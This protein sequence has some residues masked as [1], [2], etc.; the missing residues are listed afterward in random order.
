[1]NYEHTLL[2]LARQN[3]RLIILT[4]ENR[5]PIRSFAEE[6]PDRFVDAGIAEQ[7]LAG[8]AAGLALRGRIPI[9]HCLAAF[10]TMRAYEFVRTDIG[11]PSLPVKIMGTI[12]GFLSEAN[13]PTHQ[14]VEDIALM[15]TIPSMNIFCPAD[16]QELCEA[17]P[18]VLESKSPFYI[19]FNALPTSISHTHKV[20]IGKSERLTEGTDITILTYGMLTGSVYEAALKLIEAGISVNLINMRF[21]RPLDE[22]A[23]LHAARTTCM[24]ITIEDHIP[25]GGLFTAVAELLVKENVRTPLQQIA[26]KKTWFKPLLLPGLL[27]HE[28][29]TGDQ[30]ADEITGM[31]SE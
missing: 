14:A 9:V 26:L 29:F 12:P 7:S 6:L 23:V 24:L 18:V 4:A 5:G 3:S 2:H 15:R 21:V 25:T 22:N 10:I 31:L 20:E 11:Y 27:E 17:L 8:T 19:R 13:G 28:G 30:L 1:M 16:E